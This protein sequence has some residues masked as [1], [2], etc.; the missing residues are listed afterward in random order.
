MCI[1]LLWRVCSDLR[2][3]TCDKVL[4][5]SSPIHCEEKRIVYK[6]AV[7]ASRDKQK[8]FRHVSREKGEVAKM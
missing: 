4:H 8:Q 2:V 1:K 6:S 5:D 7:M 3:V